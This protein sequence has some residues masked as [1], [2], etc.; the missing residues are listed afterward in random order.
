MRWPWSRKDQGSIDEVL[1]R[2][3]AA[4]SGGLSYVTPE[5][6]TRSPT[7]K[8]IDTAISRRIAV[9]PVHVYKTS[10]KNGLEIKEKLPN[11]PVAKL[12]RYPN[13]YQSRVDYWQDAASTFIRYGRYVAVKGQGS[14]GPIR[15]LWPVKPSSI[16]VDQDID[17][18]SVTYRQGAQEIPARKIH[19]VRGPARDFLN[20]DSPVDD[21]RRAIALE[22]AAEE[23]AATFYSNGAVPLIILSYL[24]GSKGFKTPEDEKKFVENFKAA[25]SGSKRHN[26]MM[27]PP[28]FD[29]PT[30]MNIDF[31]KSQMVEA[32]KYQRTVI[33]GAFGV[34]PHLVGDLERATFNNVEQQ[35]QDFTSNCVMPVTMAF[36]A[37]MERDFLTDEDWN[38]GIRIRFNLDSILRADYKSRQ[39]GSEIQMR[40]GVINSNEWREREGMNPLSDE[41][42]GSTYYRSQNYQPVGLDQQ[43]V[44][45]EPTPN[46]PP[47]N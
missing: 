1:G 28:G 3:I 22:I 2:L 47:S 37:A 30:A 4:Q 26:A 16:S 17:N 10:T 15:Y 27:L 13:S 8:A 25:F 42:G 36:E 34:P 5:N 11:H 41:D 35:D 9:T 29:K 20:G 44:T 23:L 39:E 40:N 19:Y 12:L 31:Q 14:T 46:G 38:S 24:Q 32:R 33:A 21:V 43:G 45:N 7:I 6:C 18:L